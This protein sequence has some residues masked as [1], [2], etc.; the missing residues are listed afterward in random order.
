MADPGPSS[1]LTRTEKW[2]YVHDNAIVTVTI[3]YDEKNI[4][5]QRVDG[6][7][8]WGRVTNELTRIQWGAYIADGRF[9]PVEEPEIQE[10]GIIPWYT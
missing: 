6:K 7:P 1:S 10:E 9:E 5:I 2:R 3:S 8:L 4:V